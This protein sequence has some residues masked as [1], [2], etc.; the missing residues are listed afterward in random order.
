MARGNETLYFRQLPVGPMANFV[1]LVGDR[2]R[3]ECLVV[4][5]AWDVDAI[6]DAAETDGMKIV[7]SLVTHYHPDHVG[8]KVPG[9]AVPGGVGPMLAR[10]PGHIHVNRHEADGLIAITGVSESD[11]VR[12][13]DRDRVDV[14]SVSIELLHTPGHTPGSQCF[15]VRDRLVSG[16]TLFID[17]CGR[18]DLPG[19]DPAEMRT[20]LT[21]RLAAV[22]DA[23][24]LFPGHDYG[25]VPSA[26]MG[27]QRRTN[28]HLRAPVR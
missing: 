9:F 5:P 23:V 28:R 6:A 19:G 7:G 25:P 24:V 8:G 14:G 13:D 21:R 27:E 15:L 16:D 3:G 2:E 1:Y 4:D 11:L 10:A 18:V 17:G 12:H 22:P 20:T 26:T